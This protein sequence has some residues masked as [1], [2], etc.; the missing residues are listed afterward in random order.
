MVRESRVGPARKLSSEFKD[1][2]A[3]IKFYGSRRSGASQYKCILGM[4]YMEGNLVWTESNFISIDYL[5]LNR[6]K[7][8]ILIISQQIR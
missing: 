3:W 8:M 7:Y 2:G 5:E 6:E 4:P 1:H